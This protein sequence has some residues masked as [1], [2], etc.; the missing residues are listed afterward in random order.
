MDP[1]SGSAGRRQQGGEQ[2]AGHRAHQRGQ[3]GAE[4][5]L[6]LCEVSRQ[7][8]GSHLLTGDITGLP[9]TNMLCPYLGFGYK[10]V[11]KCYSNET[12]TCNVLHRMQVEGILHTVILKLDSVRCIPE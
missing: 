4:P 8:A 6:P 10:S 7:A 11:T 3:D 2:A 1:A 9:S 5:S 12:K